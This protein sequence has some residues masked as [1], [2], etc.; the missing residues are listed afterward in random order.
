[1]LS[2]ASDLIFLYWLGFPPFY[3]VVPV[4]VSQLNALPWF[5]LGKRV[6]V[7]GR[8]HTMLVHIP[9]EVP[10]YNC[11]LFDLDTESGIG[12]RWEEPDRSLGGRNVT[13]IGIM[14]RGATGGLIGGRLVYFVDAEKVTLD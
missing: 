10:P 9:E 11:L 8:L 5:W 14:T 2:V 3:R 7:Q 1:L 12:V 4:T 13:V 6:S